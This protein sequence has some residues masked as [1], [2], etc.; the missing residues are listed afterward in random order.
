[1]CFN[2]VNNHKVGS[3]FL[4]HLL[5]QEEDPSWYSRVPEFVVEPVV[6]VEINVS[7]MKI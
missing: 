5:Q 2:Y 4:S 3:L 7:S 6:D 1:M